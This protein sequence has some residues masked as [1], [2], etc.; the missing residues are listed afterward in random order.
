MKIFYPNVSNR[1]EK[2]NNVMLKS[3]ITLAIAFKV[4]FFIIAVSAVLNGCGS[5]SGDSDKAAES[6]ITVEPSES[7]KALQSISRLSKDKLPECNVENDTQLAHVKD[8]N[9]FYVCESGDWLEISIKGE[10]G[11]KGDQG[12]K[13]DPGEFTPE[14]TNEW[15]DALSGLT[16]FVGGIGTYVQAN[17]SCTGSYRMPTE[18]ESFAAINHG[19]LAELSTSVFWMGNGWGGGLAGGVPSQIN[20]AWASGQS[21][22]CVKN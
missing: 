14:V 16:W 19:L 2:E 15:Y 6:K 21:I 22:A 11:E 17:G 8:E 9:S 3:A 20:V 13:G 10:H 7:E 1:F 5:E 4:Q 18:P 12:D